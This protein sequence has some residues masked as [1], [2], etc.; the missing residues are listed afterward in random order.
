MREWLVQ[1]WE[2]STWQLILSALVIFLIG[3]GAGVGGAA[4]IG[5]DPEDA[6]PT[7]TP[8]VTRSAPAPTRSAP[9][10]SAPAATPSAPGAPATDNATSTATGQP[11]D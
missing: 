2:A 6:L 1:D 4:I 8:T 5:N 7:S 10:R 3:L 9:T 11:S